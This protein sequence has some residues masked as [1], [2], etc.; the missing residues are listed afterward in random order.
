MVGQKKSV[1]GDVG[2]EASEMERNSRQHERSSPAP[3]SLNPK[4]LGSRNV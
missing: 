1:P 3:Q 4:N 2:A